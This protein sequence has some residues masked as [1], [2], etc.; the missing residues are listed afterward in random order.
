MNLKNDA[1]DTVNLRFCGAGGMGAILASIILGK[2]AIYDK[3]NATQTQSYG[4][5][6]RGTK[7]KSDVIISDKE[8]ITYPVI[9]KADVL[10]ALSQEAFD[11][12]YKTTTKDSLILVNSNL[13]TIKH[14]IK[15]L[16]QIP[17][18]K[19]AKELK[20]K[21][22]VNIILL[23]ALIKLTDIVSKDSILKTISET[24]KKSMKE[25]NI[26]AFQIGY[27]FFKN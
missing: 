19:L 25:L 8:I 17:A 21:K 10:I 11:N 26:G 6:Q 7:V 22:V 18:S 27:E 2:A 1:N 20:N 9:D 3:K 4:A 15:N 12:Y 16:F 24:F 5:E 14:D 23:G 13:I